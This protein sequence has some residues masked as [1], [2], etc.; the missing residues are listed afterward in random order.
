M[1]EFPNWLE[2][3]LAFIDDPI[4]RV[5]QKATAR[6]FFF[7]NMA[8]TC[9]LIIFL[10]IARLLKPCSRGP[11]ACRRNGFGN[12]GRGSFGPIRSRMGCYCDRNSVPLSCFGNFVT[13]PEAIYLALPPVHGAPSTS[14]EADHDLVVSFPCCCMC[15]CLRLYPASILRIGL[16]VSHASLF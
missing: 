10:E 12:F 11:C 8:L 6:F 5:S 1:V 2:E 3:K 7:F 4:I 9:A 13:D 15:H 14:K 16:S